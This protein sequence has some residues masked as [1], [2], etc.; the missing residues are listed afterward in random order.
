MFVAGV[1]VA[2]ADAAIAAKAIKQGSTAAQTASFLPRPTFGLWSCELVI[3]PPFV[4]L[5][6][7]R[8]RSCA[9]LEGDNHERE[10]AED[11]RVV[12]LRAQ[13]AI[14]EARLFRPTAGGSAGGSCTT[15]LS[16]SSCITRVFIAVPLG[17]RA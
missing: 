11:R 9:D 6:R 4:G 2:I 15:G 17:V 8:A 12:A 14:F 1:A 3:L 10:R 13:R 7:S 5:E 16:G